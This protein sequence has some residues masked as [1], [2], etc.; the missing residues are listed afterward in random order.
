MNKELRYNIFGLMDDPFLFNRKR[1][2]KSLLEKV[3]EHLSYSCKFWFEHFQDIED[4]QPVVLLNDFVQDHFYQW[5]EVLSLNDEISNAILGLQRTSLNH[6]C[7]KN[8]P[9]YA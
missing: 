5:L 8:P 4:D 7:V 3:P 9:I 2:R 1:D 6:V